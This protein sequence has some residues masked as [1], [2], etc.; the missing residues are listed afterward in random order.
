MH[1]ILLYYKSMLLQMKRTREYRFNFFMS[2]FGVLILYVTQFAA[3]WVTLT[4][5]HEVA[6]WNLYELAF[7]YGLWL[8]TYGLLVTVF[9]GVRDFSQFVHRGEFDVLLVRP[10]S[11]LWQVMCGRLELTSWS[12]IG[13][14]VSILYWSCLHLD[15]TWTGG[16]FLELGGILLGGSLIQGGVLLL[17]A[18][19]SFRTIQANNFVNLGWTINA[20][21]MTYPLNVYD[22]GIRYLF[23][24]YP[25]AFI[26]YYPAASFLEKTDTWGYSLGVLSPLAGIVFFLIIYWYWQHSI[27]QYQSSG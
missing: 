4:Y 21:Y 6:G 13:M 18:A 9:A 22:N 16:K 5:F 12:H 17:W 10:H 7:M 24:V 20:N 8:L 1:A 26:T 11:A 14:A 27:K 23:T 19:I 25:M 3:L 2:I 15:I